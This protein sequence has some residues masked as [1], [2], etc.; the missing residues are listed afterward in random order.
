MIAASLLS[1]LRG[2]A[3]KEAACKCTVQPRRLRGGQMTFLDRY[4]FIRVLEKVI[5]KGLYRDM[6]MP[7]EVLP[8]YSALLVP[9]V[10]PEWLLVLIVVPEWWYRAEWWSTELS[11]GRQSGVVVDRAEWWYRAEWWWTEPSGGGQSRV[12]VRAT[13]ADRCG[14]HT[15]TSASAC[16]P[17]RAEEERG[18]CV[19]SSCSLHV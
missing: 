3:V 2:P 11:G 14:Q 18:C 9:K 8:H 10:V 4:Y 5:Q 19:Y 6:Q 13:T 17:S 12:V 7:I 15:T 16:S 1:V